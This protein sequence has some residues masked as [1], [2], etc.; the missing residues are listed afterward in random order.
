MNDQAYL[1]YRRRLFEMPDHL[2]LPVAKV[3]RCQFG[4][5]GDSF[6]LLYQPAQCFDAAGF[7]IEVSSFGAGLSEFT[8]IDDL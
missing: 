3:E 2:Q 1:P 4:Q 7:V 5:D 6:V 8:E